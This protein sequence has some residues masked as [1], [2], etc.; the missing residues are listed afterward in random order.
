MVFLIVIVLKEN[1]WNIIA[2]STPANLPLPIAALQQHMQLQQQQMQI[3]PNL[4]LNQQIA[5]LNQQLNALIEL[6]AYRIKHLSFSHR[7]SLF[8][9]LNG[10][11]NFQ[12]KSQQ[13]QQAQSQGQPG[14]PAQPQQQSQRTDTV[15]FIKHPIIY[16]NVHCAMLK[17]FNSFYGTDFYELISSLNSKAMG[18]INTESEELNKAFVI[19]VARAFQ[20]TSS[21]TY[22][23][24][25]KDREE[26]VRVVLREVSKATPIHFHDHVLQ[27]FPKFMQDFLQKEQQQHMIGDSSNKQYK[28]AL[29]RK[30]EEDYKKFL[31]CRHESQVPNIFQNSP[32]QA[33]TILW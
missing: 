7:T 15:N 10:L 30:V 17:I 28:A 11:F 32:I 20:F 24:D 16:M 14:Q 27:Y 13:Q 21:D 25:N 31:D 8:G 22:P 18:F 26:P 3:P 33:H 4:G 1:W 29:S 19:L 2:N 12:S 23:L 9:L 5:F 6:V